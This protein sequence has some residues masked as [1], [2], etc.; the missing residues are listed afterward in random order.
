MRFLTTVSCSFILYFI[1]HIF[2]YFRV[3]FHCYLFVLNGYILPYFLK[4]TR[5]PIKLQNQ[6]HLKLCLK[7]PVFLFKKSREEEDIRLIWLLW[8]TKGLSKQTNLSYLP[9][10]QARKYLLG[11][12]FTMQCFSSFEAKKSWVADIVLPLKLDYS[13][14]HFWKDSV[15]R[16]RKEKYKIAELLLYNHLKF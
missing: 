3:P 2:I 10:V 12:F 4:T 6:K 8:A 1:L 11:L 9:E 15:W 7:Q 14:L 16:E 5:A 13:E